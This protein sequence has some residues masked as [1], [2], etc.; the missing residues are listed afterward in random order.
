[1]LLGILVPVL[2]ALGMITPDS[3]IKFD[4]NYRTTITAIK[5][6]FF[7][8]LKLHYLSPHIT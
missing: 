5:Y 2:N 3:A 7:V 6:T 1:M 4:H 8:N